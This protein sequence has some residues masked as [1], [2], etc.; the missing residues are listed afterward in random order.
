MTEKYV[1]NSKLFGKNISECSTE[2]NEDG[3]CER[4]L[5]IAYNLLPKEFTEKEFAK[6]INDVALERHMNELIKDGFLEQ[7]WDTSVEA[8]VYKLTPKGE[9][10]LKK[11]RK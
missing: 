2:E 7:S 9:A 3:T 6:I 1:K 5:A 8:I 11:S 4:D 10:Y